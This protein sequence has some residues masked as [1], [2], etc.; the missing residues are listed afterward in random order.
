MYSKMIV[1]LGN[2]DFNFNIAGGALAYLYTIHI[3]HRDV[4]PGNI[5]CTIGPSGW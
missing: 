1:I 5:M 2:S 4:K 3:I